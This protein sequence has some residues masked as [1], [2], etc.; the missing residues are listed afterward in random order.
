MKVGKRSK[1]VT[2]WSEWPGLLQPWRPKSG[3]LQL[4]HV[5]MH[6]LYKQKIVYENTQQALLTWLKHCKAHSWAVTTRWAG[7]PLPLWKPV[8]PK[9]KIL[10]WACLVKVWLSQPFVHMTNMSFGARQPGFK[11][12]LCKLLAVWPW[13]RRSLS[14]SQF[15]HL[16][17]GENQCQ[18]HRVVVKIK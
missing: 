17:S 7:P 5:I 13:V 11:S 15:H 12:C 18:P 10:L 9:G 1:A 4:S 2:S 16:L 14:L 8:H 6:F 3:R